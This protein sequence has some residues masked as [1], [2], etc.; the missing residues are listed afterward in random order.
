MKP[1][2]KAFRC[3]HCGAY[4]E[5]VTLKNGERQAQCA[6]PSYSWPRFAAVEVKEE[7]ANG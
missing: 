4:P 7:K 6:C 2:V 5:I 3:R 1:A